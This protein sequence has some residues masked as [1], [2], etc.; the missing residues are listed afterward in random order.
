MNNYTIWRL[1]EREL[2]VGNS[3]SSSRIDLRKPYD[4]GNYS[5]DMNTKSTYHISSSFDIKFK[6][7]FRR[8]K[9]ELLDDIWPLPLIIVLALWRWKTHENQ[10]NDEGEG[11][12]A[13]VVNR[14]LARP[15]PVDLS[16]YWRWTVTKCSGGRLYIG[17]RGSPFWI[18]GEARK[19]CVAKVHYFECVCAYDDVICF[20]IVLLWFFFN[21]LIRVFCFLGCM[22][23]VFRLVDVRWSRF[24][25]MPK[26][27][28]IEQFFFLE[29]FL[30]VFVQFFLRFRSFKR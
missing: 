27:W 6:I 9:L 19:P 25:Q 2:L 7:L 12:R 15:V 4:K 13:G 14:T 28:S 3:D 8:R 24:R 1:W 23:S 17:A 10:S 26:T 18:G 16:R 20:C 29:N 11:P 21:N 5:C 30:F 22:S